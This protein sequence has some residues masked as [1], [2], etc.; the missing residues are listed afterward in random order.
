MGP[1]LSGLRGGR[2]FGARGSRKGRRAWSLRVEAVESLRWIARAFRA[3]PPSAPIGYIS[4]IVKSPRAFSG[5]GYLYLQPH[6]SYL[7][8]LLWGISTR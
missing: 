4:V 6:F 3:L 5:C 8:E 7:L 1:I 2:R